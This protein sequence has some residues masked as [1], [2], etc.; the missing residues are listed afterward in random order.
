MQL[1]LLD[2]MIYCTIS[3]SLVFGLVWMGEKIMEIWK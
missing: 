2:A 3:V 1:N